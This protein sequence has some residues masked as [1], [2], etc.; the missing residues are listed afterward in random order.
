MNAKINFTP[1]AS[2]ILNKLIALVT[3]AI[4]LIVG[5]AHS[6]EEA[7]IFEW[8]DSGL[9]S[10]DEAN[11]M[12]NLLEEGNQEEA[13]MLA[14][15]YSLENCRPTAN[16]SKKTHSTPKNENHK[17]RLQNKRP[18]L[19]PHG[20]VQWKGRTDSLGHL[21]SSRL[22]L[23][24]DFYRYRLRLGSQELLT[25]RND[26][27]EAYF[28]QISTREHHSYIPLDTLWGTSL[29]YPVGNFRIA[30]AIDTALNRQ[31]L[32]GYS[33]G[34]H[35][36]I[37][38]ALGRNASVEIFGWQSRQNTSAGLQA[39]ASWGQLAAWWQHGQE[40][41][42]VK[43]Q[44]QNDPQPL[45]WKVSAYFHGSEV[46][47]QAHLSK[48]ILQNQLWS[49]Q[50]IT[51]SDSS[52]WKTKLTANSR[53]T[54]PLDSSSTAKYS[55][56]SEFFS[57]NNATAQFKLQASSGP[58]VL[59]GTASVTCLDASK[60]CSQDDLK[61]QVSSRILE[62]PGESPGQI[63][64]QGSVKSRYAR[65]IG[66]GQPHLETGI[67]Y[68]QESVNSAGA[69]LILPRANPAEN[70]QVRTQAN[71]GTDFLQTSFAVTFRKKRSE[72]LH[73]LR[74]YLQIKAIF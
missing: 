26:G 61:M 13:C 12:L 6:L 36:E 69:T 66:L 1:P 63:L 62:G 9:I 19:S 51:Y 16:A 67:T 18:P 32:I 59:R 60:N 70:L 72:S 33:M 11:E 44:F 35:H 42:L 20:H 24:V 22:D 34:A 21:E 49:S 10:A 65:K 68:S 37:A 38:A 30:G 46:P 53:I 47:E 2:L 23:Q 56:A 39:R 41:P 29:L 54:V 57:L 15:A 55:K 7:A 5:Q 27:A 40:S 25:Y 74:A 3:S 28:G 43:M 52:P 48:S 31:A 17:K 50:T 73:P 58:T 14:E 45:S 4:F 71:V 8:W 64:L